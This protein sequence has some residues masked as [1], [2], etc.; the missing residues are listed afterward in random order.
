MVKIIGIILIIL[1]MCS[2]AWGGFTIQ[3]K[4]KVVEIGPIE[5][6]R[7]KT[8]RVPIAPL[9]GG[10]AVAAGIGLL[11]LRKTRPSPADLEGLHAIYGLTD[12]KFVVSCCGGS[13]VADFSSRFICEEEFSFHSGPHQTTRRDILPC[14]RRGLRTAHTPEFKHG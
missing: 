3:N 5:A 14:C 12:R 9:A 6:T 7:E 10:V 1:G 11:V 2:V 4:E 13:D 8:H